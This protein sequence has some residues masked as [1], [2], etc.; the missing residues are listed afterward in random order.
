MVSQRDFAQLSLQRT[1]SE[2]QKGKKKGKKNKDSAAESAA[3]PLAD[4]DSEISAVSGYETPEDDDDDDGDVESPYNHPLARAVSGDHRGALAGGRQLSDGGA[5]TSSPAPMNFGDLDDLESTGGSPP[6]ERP[7]PLV[8]DDTND[9]NVTIVGGEKGGKK[10]GKFRRKGKKKKTT[11]PASPEPEP[12]PE[13]EP[14]SVAT[15]MV[16]AKGGFGKRGQ[17]LK[18]ST[19]LQ[20]VGLSHDDD[21]TAGDK[22]ILGSTS[23]LAGITKTGSDVG[24]AAGRTTSHDERAK[25]AAGSDFSMFDDMLAGATVGGGGKGMQRTESDDL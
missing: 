18:P 10:A 19:G 25:A 7:T 2:K 6:V 21:L 12:E 15:G 5:N 22:Y 11:A 13:P 17:G 24:V 9:V 14:I 23:V 3:N 4:D 8:L 16:K 20:S 1:V